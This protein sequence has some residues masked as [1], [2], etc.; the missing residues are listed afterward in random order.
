MKITN[1]EFQRFKNACER[2]SQLLGL[3]HFTRSYGRC[4]DGDYAQCEIDFKKHALYLRLGESVNDKDLYGGPE[5]CAVHEMCHALTWTLA[6]LASDHDMATAHD[7]NIARRFENM[8]R[9]LLT[10]KQLRALGTSKW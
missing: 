2:L 4:A 3:Q 8:F 1:K 9:A 5:L 7:E 6:D 10:P